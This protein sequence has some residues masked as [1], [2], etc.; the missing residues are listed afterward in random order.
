MRAASARGIR[1]ALPNWAVGNPNEANYA[2]LAPLWDAFAR[3]PEHVY[4]VHEY[5]NDNPLAEPWHVGRFRYAVGKLPDSTQIAITEYGRDLG[6]G[7]YDG[8][9]DTG[10]TDAAYF[11]RLRAPVDAGIYDGIPLMIFCAGAGANGRWRSFDVANADELKTL[12][13]QVPYREKTDMSFDY[14][15]YLRFRVTA[16]SGQWVNVRKEAGATGADSIVGRINVDDT[17]EASRNERVL[18]DNRW[19]KVRLE[20]GIEGYAAWNLVTAE[21]VVITEPDPVPTPD[22]DKLCIPLTTDELNQLAA[23]HT[24]IAR[25][26]T[27]IAAIYNAALARIGGSDG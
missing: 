23:H 8:W 17:L 5:F 10:W 12:L 15:D 4:A 3:H 20:N 6:G 24:D 19:R 25:L 13:T 11:A 1:L 9:R 21:F 18:G 2:L 22:P 16:T 14:G 27:A 7:E 26:H